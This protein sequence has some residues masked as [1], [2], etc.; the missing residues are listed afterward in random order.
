[1]S[2]G[3]MQGSDRVALVCRKRSHRRRPTTVVLTV[4]V[5]TPLGV[6]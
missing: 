1:M 5:E 6:E 4:W 2:L 3:L